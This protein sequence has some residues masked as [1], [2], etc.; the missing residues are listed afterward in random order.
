MKIFCEYRSRNC[1]AKKMTTYTISDIVKINQNELNKKIFCFE[2]SLI[3][4]L[5]TEKSNKGTFKTTKFE[6]NLTFDFFLIKRSKNPN[7]ED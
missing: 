1:D 3:Q 5:R 6:N 4:K 2:P 7:N